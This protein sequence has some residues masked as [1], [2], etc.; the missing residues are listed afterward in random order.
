[1][2]RIAA[3]YSS[4]GIQVAACVAIGVLG[5]LWLDDHFGTTPW[6]FWI[7]LA[8]GVT[9]AGRSV[10]RVVKGTHLSEM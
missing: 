7:G 4:I 6:L 9:A 5:G 2:W 8:V 10:W 3:R 1:M